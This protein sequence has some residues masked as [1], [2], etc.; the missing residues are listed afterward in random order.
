[1]DQKRLKFQKLTP[2]DDIDLKVYR[3]AL[4]FAFSDDEIK[5]IAISGQ[6]GAGKSSLLET[7]K[8]END[9]KNF[10]HISLA[11]FN[12]RLLQ[13]NENDSLRDQENDEKIKESILEGRILNQLIH[14]T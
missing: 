7:Y 1:M 9:K 2:A 4:D 14:Q 6:Y 8:K 5:N 3:D 13:D 10:V 12:N 11:H